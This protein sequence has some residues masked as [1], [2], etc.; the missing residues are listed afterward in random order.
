MNVTFGV[1]WY[2]V[3][4]CGMV[5]SARESF[6]FRF[7]LLVEATMP[8][9]CVMKIKTGEKVWMALGRGVDGVRA[10]RTRGCLF[11]SFY[12]CC[13]YQGRRWSNL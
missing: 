7:L 3:V 5:A 1:V 8:Q 10:R 2:G 4:W 9:M 6:V 11:L 13:E 12:Y